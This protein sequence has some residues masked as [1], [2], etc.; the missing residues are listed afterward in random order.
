M[1]RA[2]L[3]LVVCGCL[4]FRPAIG[5]HHQSD[6]DPYMDPEGNQ[7]HQLYLD[8]RA[9]E[10][11]E[12][13]YAQDSTIKVEGELSADGYSITIKNYSGDRSVKVKVLDESGQEKEVIRSRCFIDPVLLH[14]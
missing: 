11:I 10:L 3:I 1:K 7:W 14:L 4:F 9:T 6:P 8:F 13:R 12:M 2:R 5:Q